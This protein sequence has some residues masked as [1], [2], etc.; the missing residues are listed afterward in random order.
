[1]IEDKLALYHP[2]AIFECLDI[3]IF[4]DNKIDCP[5]LTVPHKL[6]NERDFVMKP[7]REIL[8]G[9]DKDMK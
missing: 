4:G 9:E 3:L 2:F 8:P 7:L 1:M 6:M 5:E